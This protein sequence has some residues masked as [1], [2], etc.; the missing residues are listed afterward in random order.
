MALR[1]REQRLRAARRRA[2]PPVHDEAAALR[3]ARRRLAARRRVPRRREG[4]VPTA[5]E[6]ACREGA[7]AGRVHVERGR[8]QLPPELRHCL[9]PALSSDRRVHHA[10][11]S[12]RAGSRRPASRT[13]GSRTG[14]ATP[15][16]E[17]AGRRS[18]VVAETDIG[19]VARAARALRGARRP[20]PIAALGE[21]VTGS[22]V[23][24]AA[25]R[26]ARRPRARGGV[27]R[28]CRRRRTRARRGC[29]HDLQLATAAGARRDTRPPLVPPLLLIRQKPETLTV[30]IPCSVPSAL[31]AA[32]EPTIVIATARNPETSGGLSVTHAGDLFAV[33]VGASDVAELKAPTGATT[34]ASCAYRLRFGRGHWTIHGGPDAV[35]LDGTVDPMPV[36]FGL[37]SGLDIRSPAAPTID[38]TTAVHDTETTAGQT[39]AWIIARRLPD[40]SS[41]APA[42]PRSLGRVR[43]RVCVPG[44]REQ[45]CT[46]T[47]PTRSWS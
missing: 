18:D 35:S 1:L 36:V 47:S 19:P 8:L 29:A 11:R 9:R 26:M 21:R 31:P 43:L 4:R 41:R 45:R 15:G 34:D 40:R 32:D 17:A 28:R 22:R 38:V 25:T 20:R 33:R 7:P 12:S 37:F 46:P 6:H 23:W 30:R 14:T 16:A 24:R 44:S 13:C 42:A 5:R 27:A 2:P 3:V 10:A 39:I